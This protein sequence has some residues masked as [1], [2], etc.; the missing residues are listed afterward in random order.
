MI[1]LE[2]LPKNVGNLGKIIIPQALKS[3]P[4]CNKLPNLGTLFVT[5]LASTLLS[6]K[7]LRSSSLLYSKAF[8]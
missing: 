1:S 2:K 6:L 8:V 4:K 7:P 3:C 5:L